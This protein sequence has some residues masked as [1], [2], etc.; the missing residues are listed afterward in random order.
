MPS[1]RAEKREREKARVRLSYFLD[2]LLARSQTHRTKSPGRGAGE[3]IEERRQEEEKE[4]ERSAQSPQSRRLFPF[5]VLLGLGALFFCRVLAPLC[6]RSKREKEKRARAPLPT[7]SRLLINHEYLK[8]KFGRGWRFA[9]LSF[10][11]S[12]QL[13]SGSSLIKCLQRGIW[14]S[15]NQR[16][17]H[18]SFF[19]PPSIATAV[20]LLF[21][22]QKSVDTQ[23]KF[24][25]IGWRARVPR[26]DI[27][28]ASLKIARNF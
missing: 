27:N 16:E 28:M 8:E 20:P 24:V 6:D 1:R 15:T 25:Y 10:S 21:T 7:F 5:F 2:C 4:G 23:L 22:W 18:H 11:P 9:S 19:S 14:R 12:P 13:A 26:G 3:E 17:K